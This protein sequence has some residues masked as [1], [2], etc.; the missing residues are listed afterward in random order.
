[1]NL[2]VK[3]PVWFWIVAVILL[4][5][6][7]MGV[8]AFYTEMNMTS[9]EEVFS[10]LPEAWQE[11]YLTQPMWIKIAFGT[12]VWSGLVA[13]IML[14]FKKAFA[15][16]LFILSILAVIIYDIG[17]FGIQGAHNIIGNG[18]IFMPILVILL[19]IFQ[20]WFARNAREKTWIN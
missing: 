16:P 4:I 19:C 1:M 11:M 9:N 18:A 15:V 13:C 17:I 2:S 3:I 7:I 5:W 6:N 12:A 14:V 8:I 10:N 20:V